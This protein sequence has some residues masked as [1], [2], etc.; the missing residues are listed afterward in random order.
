MGQAARL[1]RVVLEFIAQHHGTRVAGGFHQKARELAEREGRPPP[2]EEPFRYPGPKPRTRETG[3]VM[4]AD[5]VEAASRGI[6]EATPERLQAL[7]PRIVEPIVI[8]GQLDE[9]DLTMA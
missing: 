4:L 8:E 6:A 3:L 7:V 9:C 1:P 5:A 2:A